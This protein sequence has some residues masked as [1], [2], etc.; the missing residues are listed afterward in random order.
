MRFWPLKIASTTFWLLT[1]IFFFYRWTVERTSDLL[2]FACLFTVLLMFRT[3]FLYR[4]WQ[5]RRSAPA[6][7]N[8]DVK[9]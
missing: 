3:Y 9:S 5:A 8:H 4:E 6:M 1:A 7:E 2:G